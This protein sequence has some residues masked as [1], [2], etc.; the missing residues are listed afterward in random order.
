MG[1]FLSK[2]L[3]VQA[4]ETKGFMAT[5]NDDRYRRFLHRH[6][7]KLSN[8]LYKLIDDRAHDLNL[9]TWELRSGSKAETVFRGEADIPG[10][11]VLW[12]ELLLF[13]MNTKESTGYLRHMRA[14]PPLDFDPADAN[15][16]LASF[17]SDAAKA[18]VRDQ[19]E[20]LYAELEKP[21]DRLAL[22][23]TIGDPSYDFEDY[24]DEDTDNGDDDS[25]N[26]GAT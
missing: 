9:N 18:E 11:D 26:E 3:K 13:F 4:L 16:F 24:H 22:M 2:H 20:A 21:G 12:K 25:D 7:C 8:A 6:V 5:S 19:L 17:R 14:I 23:A 10:E 1:E 15:D